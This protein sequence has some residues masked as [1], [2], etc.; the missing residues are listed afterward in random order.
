M[1]CCSS[2]EDGRG[3]EEDYDCDFTN[4]AVGDTVGEFP[5]ISPLY[6]PER[7]KK[8]KSNLANVNK[9]DTT[10]CNND[11]TAHHGIISGSV[12]SNKE[13]K[14]NNVVS[15]K[16]E[17]S[18]NKKKNNDNNDTDAEQNI[19]MDAG[20]WDKKATSYHS[21]QDTESGSSS[22]VSDDSKSDNEKPEPKKLHLTEEEIEERKLREENRPTHFA[23]NTQGWGGGGDLDEES[24]GNDG[25]MIGGDDIGAVESVVA[26]SAVDDFGQDQGED[27][28]TA[29]PFP[30]DRWYNEGNGRGRPPAR[31]SWYQTNT[32]VFIE[33]SPASSETTCSVEKVQGDHFTLT[34]RHGRDDALYT[35][36]IA[37]F[38]PV[39]LPCKT[40]T[41]QHTLQ[42]NLKKKKCTH[43][44]QLF[45]GSRVEI[46]KLSWLHRDFSK[47]D[48]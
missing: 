46:M 24:D 44:A 3:T 45:L 6:S 31:L 2:A 18:S 42:I 25:M 23:V 10:E 16:M 7:K 8:L 9:A 48:D 20:E 4:I 19:D 15:Q 13:K 30:D 17:L 41:A 1:G 38:A 11:A 43:W 12:A 22:N 47:E 37:L 40:C 36:E 33:I 39:Q 14:D 27:R 26:F 32:N 21:S 28:N 29:T 35:L 34:Y 5:P